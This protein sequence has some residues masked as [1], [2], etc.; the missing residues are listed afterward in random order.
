MGEKG[1]HIWGEWSSKREPLL[2]IWVLKAYLLGMQGLTWEGAQ[3]L[4]QDGM[5]WEP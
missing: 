4:F 1:G 3:R 5:A 2:V